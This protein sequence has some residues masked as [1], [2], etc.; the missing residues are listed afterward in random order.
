MSE[1]PNEPGEEPG[2]D[3][4]DDPVEVVIWR[5]RAAAIIA[6]VL[7]AASAGVI[8]R[9]QSLF[10]ATD[11]L[12]APIRLAIAIAFPLLAIGTLTVAAGVWLAAVELVG[13]TRTA[14][15]I[16]AI[17]EA[18]RPEPLLGVAQINPVASLFT[19]E[20]LTAFGKLRGASAVLIV[21]VVPLVAAAAIAISAVG[22]DGSADDDNDTET[23]QG[24]GD[25]ADADI[26][27]PAPE[28]S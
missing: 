3:D 13:R 1:E 7:L 28:P 4:G 22:G 23:S 10:G 8:W 2:N 18:A 9:S 27:E 11:G 15:E 6:L 26:E 25:D 14:K 20:A 16:K 17:A 24:T 21:G 12:D 5:P 19:G